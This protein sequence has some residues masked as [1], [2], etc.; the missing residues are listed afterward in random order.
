[1]NAPKI[2]AALKEYKV[3][4]VADGERLRLTGETNRL[5]EALM[6]TVKE[7]K[8]ELLSYLQSYA[9]SIKY[10]P[11]TSLHRQE[12]Y[13]LSAAQKRLWLLS[14]QEGGNSTYNIVVGLHLKGN[15]DPLVIEQG[16]REIL[17]RHESLR[18]VFKEVDLVPRQFVLDELPFS[19]RYEDVSSG[20]GIKEFIY[21]EYQA[22]FHSQF[23]LEKGPLIR[24]DMYRIAYREY[25]LFLTVHHIVSD[26]WS[27]ALMLRE[28]MVYYTAFNSGQFPTDQPLHIQYRDYAAWHTRQINELAPR[29]WEQQ[30]K[31][32]STQLELPADFARPVIKSFSGAISRFYWNNEIY[33]HIREFCKE[34]RTTVF[35][36]FHAT[37]SILLNKFSGQ[38]DI[39]I[40]TPVSGR[41]HHELEDQVGLYVNTVPLRTQVDS[42]HTFQEH[43]EAVSRQTRQAFEFQ[44]YPLDKII[45]LAPVII[46]AGR[47]PL[48]D[49]LMVVQ[50]NPPV[51]LGK[52]AGIVMEDICTYLSGS[53]RFDLDNVN[54]KL[55]L[56]FNF[57]A[58][59]N[60]DGYVEIEYATHLYKKDTVVRFYQAFS[61]ITSQVIDNPAV[62]IK[63]IS[64]VT[65]GERE[66]LV[67]GFNDTRHPY[68]EDKTVI[69]L[70]KKQALIRPDHTAV[71]YKETSLSY[72]E[73]DAITNQVGAYLRAKYGIGAGDLVGVQLER[74]EWQLICLIGVLKA[75][76]AYV[77]ID[78][79]F[80]EERQ[81]YI[82]SDSGCKVVLDAKLLTALRAALDTYSTEG[83][84]AGTTSR[85]PMYVIYTSGSTGRPK[86]CILESRGVMNRLNWMWSEFSLDSNDVILQKTSFT[87]DVSVSELFLP[88]CIGAT[89]VMCPTE[90]VASPERLLSLVTMEKI[91]CLHFVPSMLNNF[92]NNDI[93]ISLLSSVRMVMASGEALTPATVDRWYAQ[94]N[95]PLYNLYGPTEA[96][97]EVSYYAT[98]A[99]DV[100]IPIGRPIWNTQIHI[101]GV[102]NEVLPVGVKGEICIGGDGLARGYLNNAALTEEKFIA[103]PFINGGRLYRTG[104]IGYRTADGLVVYAGRKDDQVKVRGYRI[105]LG[106]ISHT[107][108]KYA[109]IHDAVVIAR[110]GHDGEHELIAYVTGA[111]KLDLNKIRAHLSGILPAYMIPAY[112]MQLDAIPLNASGKADRKALPAP[113]G[114]SL[115][116][117]VGARTATESTL[118]NIWSEIL[119]L[120][121][122]KI[123][124]NDNFFL[125]GGHS[126]K[127]TR[128]ISQLHRLF[129]VK[130]S[131]KEIFHHPILEDLANLVDASVR[132]TFEQIPVVAVGESYALSSAQRR[133]WIL[134]QLEGGNV[135]Y[136]IPAAYI[137]E[138]NLD[139]S[140]LEQCLNE[141][142]ARHEIL[143][144]FFR[145]DSQGEVRQF[146]QPSIAFTINYIDL[147]STPADLNSLL[148]QDYVE[149][150]DLSNGSLLRATLYQVADRRWVLGFVMHHII[151]DG[152]SMSVLIRELLHLYTGGSS[153]P[154]LRIQYKDYSDWQAQ[155]LH[156]ADRTYWHERFYGEMPVLELLGD[157]PRP[158][159]KTYHGGKISRLLRDDLYQGLKQLS[160]QNLFSGLVALVTALL[161]R[162]TG[163]EDI[164]IGSPVSG[165]DHIDLEDQIGFYVN[166][167]ALRSR[168]SGDGDFRGLLSEVRQ[169][170]LDGYTHQSYPFDALVDELYLERDASR[171]PLFDVVVVL[172][173]D[174]DY[175]AVW[176]SQSVDVKVKAYE[177]DVLLT[178]KFDLQFT[179]IESGGRLGAELIYNSD[180]YTAST[181]LQLLSHLEQLLTA[182]LAT[183]AAAISRLDYLGEIAQAGGDEDYPKA[184]TLVSLFE[185]QV[186]RTPDQLAVVNGTDRLT[187]H[188]VNARANQLAH[189]LRG[190]HGI[191]RNDLVSMVLDRGVDQVI[192]MLGVLKA[193]GGY[194]P[195]D[196]EYPSDRINY[197][198]TD[199]GSR[200]LLDETALASACDYSEE[201]PENINH[202]DDIA[203]V[204]YTSGT[205]GN[206]KGVVVAHYNVV[207][208]LFT[209]HPLYDFNSTD[210]WTMYHSY[211]FDFSVWEM[212][213]ALLYGGKLVVVPSLVARDPSQFLILLREE[214]VTVLNQTPSAFY[215]LQ[216]ADNGEDCHQ[217]RYVIFGGEALSPGNLLPWK[218]RYPSCRLINMYGITETT[219][220]VTY[221]ELSLSD[222]YAGVSNI[223]CPIPTLR[224]YVLDSYGQPVPRGV[225]GELYVGG[226]GVARGYLNREELTSARFVNRGVERLYRSGDKV[227]FLAGGELEY[228]GRF[229]DQVKIRGYRIEIGEITARL[230]SHEGVSAAV[231]LTGTGADGNKELHAYIVGSSL[232]GLRSYLGA[233]L[234]SYMV[235]QRM[236]RVSA[237]P[238]NHN[239]K[240]DRQL[241]VTMDGEEIESGE[242]YMAP[243]TAVEQG[244]VHVWSELLGIDAARIGIHSNFFELGGHSLKAARL[245]S[246][247]YQVFEV[248]V[249][250]REIFTYPELEQQALLLSGSTRTAFAGIPLAPVQS[251]YVLSS[252]QRRIW[253]LSQLEGGSVAYNITGAYVFTGSL[254][255]VALED[256]FK[257]LIARH[258]VL[259][260]VFR[261]DEGE[262]R[263]FILPS[264][265]F[266][267]H[268]QDYVV[269]ANDALTA[270]FNYVFNLSS[271]PLLRAC[272]YQLSTGKWLFSFVIHHIISDGWSIGVFIRELLAIYNGTAAL[273]PLRIQYKDYA[274]WQATQLS[275]A[276]L[277][278]HRPYWL[279]QFK[280]ELP[281]LDIPGTFTRP[282]IKTYVGARIHKK[283]DQTLYNGLKELANEQHATLFMTLVAAV[284]V[285]LYR[286]TGQEDI[287]IGSPIAGRDHIDLEEQIGLYANTLAIRSRFKGQDTFTAL[288]SYVRERTLGANAHQLLPFDT[289]LDELQISHD[290]SRNALFEVEVMLQNGDANV[291]EQNLLNGLEIK[292][293]EGVRNDTSRFDLVFDFF[294][295]V[296]GLEVECVYNTDIYPEK[297]VLQILRHLEQLCS[298]ILL[299]PSAP[300]NELDYLHTAEQQQLLT[301][302]NNTAIAYPDNSN[303]VSLFE[304]QAEIRPDAAAVVF[305]KTV[306]SYR[307]LDERAN[308]LAHYLKEN[309]A[310]GADQL[311]AIMLDRS[312][313]LIVAILGILKSGAAYVPIDPAYPA[314][315]KKYILKDTQAAILLTQTD[316]IFDLDYFEGG[317]FVMDLQM[318]T[319]DTPVFSPAIVISNMDLA[320]VIYTSGSTGNPKGVMIAHEAIVNTIYAQKDLF[321]AVA[322]EKHLQF[323]S[324]SFDAS[325]SE[326]FVALAAGAVLCIIEE[327][328]KKQPATLEKYITDEHI[329]LATLPPAIVKLLSIPN[330]QS[331]K[332]LVTAGEAAVLDKAVAFSQTG[333]YINAYGPTES[334][335]C[336]TTFSFNATAVSSDTVPI[337]SPI[338]N[339]RIY[340]LDE[341]A[342]LLPVGVP[343]EIYIAG[344][345]LAKGY[346]NNPVLTAEKFCPDPFREGERMYRTGD[347]GYWLPDGVLSFTGRRDEQVKVR[348]YRIELGEIERTLQQYTDI[349]AAAAI[350]HTDR[351]GESM[352]V[353]YISGNEELW[354]ESI[355]SWLITQLPEYMIPNQFI[356][357]PVLPLNA[358][359]KVDK[360]S[361]PLPD[362]LSA[363]KDYVA[364]GNDIEWGIAEIWSEVLD[365]SKDKISV[366]DN[367]FLLG[368]HSLKATRLVGHLHRR[369]GVKVELQ[370]LFSHPVLE[371][372]AKLIDIGVPKTFIQIPQVGVQESYA[373]S[374]AQRRLWILSQLEGGNVAYNIPAAYI[375]EGNLDVSKLEQCLN[376]LIAR[377]EILRT[378]FREDSQGEVRQFI[379]PSI[380]FTINYIDLRS[381]PAD[382]NS[383]LT[384]DYVEA[385]DLSN[386]SLLRATLYQVAD[387]QW[388]LGFVMHH[389][390]SDGWS[391]SVLI[392]EL[393]HL[394]T[395]GSSLPALRIQYKDYSDW[396]AQHLHEADR[397]YWHERFYGEMPVLELLGDKPRP[398]QKTYHGGKIS[399]LL[400]D[401][402]Y[403][404]LKQLSSQNLFSGLVALVTALL[405]RYTGQED[406]I[407]GSP[408]SGRDHID[409]EDQIGFYVNMLALR[410]RF[411]GDGDFRG[412]LSEVRQQILDG[413]THQSYPFD[414][415]VDELYLER[416]ASRHPLFDVVVVLQQDVDYAAVWNSQ[417]VDVKVKAYEEDVLLTSKFD[418]QFTFIESGG[419][420]GAELIYNSDIYTASTGLQLLSHL[421]QLLTA[422]LAT[423][424]AAISRLDYLGE[425]AQ[426]GGDEEYPKAAT[427]VSL[428]EQQV[429]RTPD[430]LAVVNGTDRLTYHEVNARAN[431]LA[432]YLRGEHGIGRNDLVSMVLDRGVDQVIGMLGVLKAGG[433]YVPVDV[434]YPS[435]RIN[436]IL[437]DSGS[438]FLLDETALAAACDYSEENPENINHPDDI[439]YV[440]YTSG[441]T[442]NPKGVVVAHYNVV[443]LLFTEHPLYDFNSTD[444]WTMYHSYCFDFSVWEMY[445]ALLYGGKLVVV[446]SLVA[447]DPSQ[448]LI[449]LREEGVTVLNQTPSAFYNLQQADN[450]EDCHQLRYVIFGGE[451][452]SPGNLLP[453]KLRY[454]SCRLINMY[455]ITETTVHVTYKELSLSDLYAGV[456]NIGCPIPTLRCYVLDSY[457]QPVPRGVAGELYVGG[458]GVARGYLN[459]EELTSARFV[460]RGVERLYRSGDKVRFLAGGELEYLG[461]FDD[462]VKIRGYRIEIGEIT[463][464]L[465]SHEGVSAAVVLTGTGADGNKELHAYIVGSSL[466]GLRSYLGAHLPS[467]MVPQRMIR[468]S[469]LPLNHNGK[470]DRQLLVT[471][472]G[473]EIESGEGY[474]APRTAVEQGL[475]HV[476]SELLGIDAARIGIHS[477]FFELGGHSLKAARLVSQLYQVFE[478]KVGIREI[479]TY[480]ELEQQALLLSGST[481][482]AFAGIP[483]APVQSSYVLSSSQRRIWVLS[484]LEGGSVAYNIPGA[485]EFEG[486]LDAALLE[487]AFKTLIARHE[488][489]R[490][491]FREDEEGEV[492]QFILPSI[493]FKLHYQDH[494]VSAND[495]LIADFNYVFDLSSGP[496]LRACLYQ[497]SAGKWLFSFVIHHIISDGW[498]IGVFIQELL[499]V[500]NG[501]GTLPPLRIQYKDYADWQAA[502]LSGAALEAHR[503][504]WLDKFKGELPVMD[505]VTDKVRPLI[506]SY[507]GSKVEKQLS[508]DLT[509]KLKQLV[510]ATGSTLFIGM[511]A[512]V[513]TL[514]YRY[515]GQEDIIVGS[516]VAGR[517]HIDLE[518][519]IGFYVNT[520]A[521][522]S[523]FN[524]SDNFESLLS[525]IH[526]QTLEAYAHQ[527]YPFD[528]LIDELRLHR[529]MSR[530][531]LF[532]VFVVFHNESDYRLTNNNGNLRITPYKDDH[533]VTCKFDLQFDFT[534]DEDS[535]QVSVTYSPDIFQAPRIERLV[536]H[537]EQLL[538]TVVAAPATPLRKL[539]YLL[540][541]ER[542]QLVYG[543]NDTNHLFPADKTIIDL[544]REQVLIRPDHPAV[545]YNDTSLSYSQLDRITNQVGAYLRKEYGISAGDLVGVQLE[546]SEWQLICLIGVLKAGGAYVPIDPAF[547]EERRQYIV[548]DSKC[549]V[550]LTAAA[551]AQLQAALP[552]YSTEAFTAGTTSRD[553]MYVLYTSGSTGRPK[554]CMLEYRGV[555]NRLNWMWREYSLGSN[556]I[557]LQKTSFTFDVS[558]WEIFLPLCVGATEVLCPAE[559]VA[560]PGRL[561][562]LISREAVTC[563][564]FVPSMLNSFLGSVVDAALLKSVR[565]VI[566]SG[567]ALTPATVEL[568]YELVNIPLH[569]LYG[570]TEASIDVS[571]YATRAEEVII[572]I[573]RPIWNTQLYILGAD[574]EVLPTS[575][576]GEICIGGDGLA[577][578]YLNNAALTEEKFTTDP[579]ISDGRLYHTGD[580]GYRTAN[581]LIVYAGRK[582]DQVKVRGYRIEL[583]EIVHA[584]QQ[585]EDIHEATVIARKGNDGENELI[586]YITA[587]VT[588]EMESIRSYLAGILPAYMLPSYYVQ[589]DAMPLNTSGKTD[590]KALPIPQDG[591]MLRTA[592]AYVAP[593]NATESGLVEIWSEVL[594]ISKDK[595]GV[596]DNFFD[597]GA[598]SLKAVKV[599]SR[600]HTTFLI[601]INLQNIFKEPTIEHL[602][603]QIEFI[604]SQHKQTKNTETLTQIDI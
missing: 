289:L 394:Y 573:G 491:V 210:V 200:F 108:Q 582:D 571:Y 172:Q 60:D 337:G 598:H 363:G 107:L 324:P 444:V 98:H 45:E 41:N 356:Q 65:P 221:K 432:H 140:K 22:M 477:N 234:P 216:Q 254:D 437:T 48:F 562:S 137:F 193:G 55:D 570:P 362:G 51:E 325:V 235:P 463:A 500:Y 173:Q 177:E 158:A 211:C 81:Q 307:E 410:S 483:L 243:R 260:T 257:T 497:L 517:E 312:E 395:G 346:L 15:I 169:Q 208:L 406:I 341:N 299:H 419:R 565:M 122:D 223:G 272:L 583:G 34:H 28:L 316:Y 493:D 6:T 378:F 127:A 430:Q 58:G 277:E 259:R 400:R 71:K 342:R 180:I 460:N 549:K 502:Q 577:R 412:L 529:D 38:Q 40:G 275:G 481:R 111:E 144:T 522:R 375:F 440:I 451:A 220:H 1:M 24:A 480:P 133:L 503:A 369:F 423:P 462:Q 121:S 496:L 99:G 425:I 584:L 450:G 222:L 564:H 50:Q 537:F 17:K 10:T 165:R 149:A 283:I 291:L 601:R 253:V 397:T 303:I 509:R 156:E 239:G 545:K 533:H 53:N 241:L 387:R 580:I 240:V 321:G 39:V 550:V 551:L 96:S 73:L 498:S 326:I 448:F 258:E 445:G 72:G 294:E 237:L 304:T 318:D 90:D 20:V 320:Y 293:Y 284:N 290:R 368:G 504:Y 296:N 499:H 354:A 572:P 170:I 514:L 323:A 603:G 188:E 461:R 403:Q 353:A 219:V 546:R 427:L 233:H 256:A 278:N 405:Y 266:K 114:F 224:C 109:D 123:S 190:E 453:W 198:L 29:Y 357:L 379:Q 166:M 523:R 238:L 42:G 438:R 262:V 94:V 429:A 82:V 252:S 386:G 112:F 510:N 249:G 68:V 195:V 520:L 246:Q 11:V 407:I 110:K 87:F 106:E 471:M 164:I 36:F 189:Y 417:S 204:I 155:H 78:P 274:T 162:Y 61:Y 442:G 418:L 441:T 568:W 265:D 600:I 593:R 330:I 313:K 154:A 281:V 575:V 175:A 581:G 280:G 79:T 594:G 139:V 183:P 101:L 118:V 487:D 428:F 54:A 364:P 134:S 586:A 46:D 401:D 411:S 309:Y 184:A 383:L 196:V 536:A 398:A 89:E 486:Q 470:V 302:F 531:P 492:R 92:L 390:I 569:N 590:R 27:V 527:V 230:Q 366:K 157:K 52:S 201:N 393:L 7:N 245:V 376:E 135:A 160:S 446:P 538:S 426:A 298:D 436:Y 574:N 469:A 176:N 97:I 449:L 508:I 452:L 414:A 13:E 482:T 488:V 213:G 102:D 516:A 392:R 526:Q 331:L 229:D 328:K 16:L 217:L 402:L 421:E 513:K 33:A 145:E 231:V 350:V 495:V 14:Q 431:Q 206:P 31:D 251:S 459:R 64:I 77:P 347:I 464:R 91:T 205:T 227:R 236:I 5:P 26:G 355:R 322:G 476:W 124:V 579:F 12:H 292:S 153:L 494:V 247:L 163:Q 578:G 454:P 125:L 282:A 596:R 120:S 588:L 32:Y 404:G 273:S 345:G 478:V 332:R 340:V 389:I 129:E 543:F 56:S 250:I 365:V 589:L 479:F 525:M 113:D 57:A 585:Y 70:F 207:R 66:Q 327:E 556:D 267:L 466:S 602:A 348:G 528:S 80:P 433:G 131:L 374:S 128:L 93:D 85:D 396:Q 182:I 186:A 435:D 167:L 271:G 535:I 2:I 161:Y 335:I 473:E 76:G 521:L 576:R 391:M 301:T 199:S 19:I 567:E 151:S 344:R 150:F 268:Y 552:A 47:N 512:A 4:P 192:G 561:L 439:A 49:V 563:L 214:G 360:R 544:F 306:L 595:I 413:Y 84:V 59:T 351:H 146:I 138:G 409:L 148:T 194:V 30:F 105:E 555:V 349:T 385:F 185:Q 285:L 456:S 599:I 532:D 381:T 168:F 178:S 553:L 592:T 377:H 232:S 399:H 587:G 119:G 103:D 338:A 558:V 339:T 530:H 209:E 591:S 317:M 37:L 225:A 489:L 352:L 117:Y 319:I 18:T 218:L 361:L 116:Q 380:A 308:Q 371:E 547:P 434:E 104:D 447:R 23:D 242:G 88:L 519:Q 540:P 485:Y 597:L 534:E 100:I 343:G 484:Q 181:G 554:G 63:Q 44:D 215:N 95:I 455:G 367:F 515:T 255:K 422:I 566:A 305:G 458:A 130:I 559:D 384:Q 288:L 465:Q 3:V 115:T 159:Q 126:L 202:P 136:N 505:L 501:G 228:L 9:D 67:H 457:G 297:L 62:L 467:Y 279:D 300:I 472:D 511:M 388:V 248:K 287:I 74:S 548:S 373:L 506:K 370:D 359:G 604:L 424:A 69:D 21:Q 141:L 314:S 83:Y 416:D 560:S 264:I 474:V 152:W 43:L 329:A 191:G 187:Y 315:R 336:A 295:N 358:S 147:R 261:E 310:A 507:A 541:G 179:F 311:I 86:G 475:V 143:R 334:S 226:A 276:A 171:H 490:T 408:V 212:Y 468:V 269:S 372:Q 270:D 333:K 524:G 286:Y 263:Q 244:L 542:E 25:A 174:V 539:N 142:I 557:I 443:R 518:E 75:G 415:L 203:Y 420:L 382:L 132:T 197:I 8:S 35:N